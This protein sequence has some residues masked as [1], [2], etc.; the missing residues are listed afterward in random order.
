MAGEIVRSLRLKLSGEEEKGLAKRVT[1][2]T[3]AYQEYLRGRHHWNKRTV[4]GLRSALGHFQKA[5]DLDPNF[6]I[7]YT[8]LADTFN[9]LGYYNNQRPHDAYPK[10]KAAA[11]RAL[12][13]DATLAEAHSSMGYIQI[14]YDLDWPG[15]KASFERALAINPNYATAHHWFAWYWFM[16]EQFDEALAQLR[17]AQ[18]LDPLSL[19]IN[20]HL[21]YALLLAGK[22]DEALEHLTLTKELDPTFPWTYWRLGSVYLELG[23][24]DDAITA[25]GTVVDMTKGGVGLGYYG[26]ALARGGRLDDARAVVTRLTDMQKTRYVSPLEFA[27]VRAG[28][29]ETDAALDALQ[30]AYDDRVSDFARVKLLPWPEAVRCS[31]RFADLLAKLGVGS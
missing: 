6:A 20:D 25:F 22:P 26:L 23:R 5:I 2:N 1:E 30:G 12:A 16:V 13:L 18:E 15:A 29:G 14:F 19:I 24:V 28:L 7:A 3:E 10:G 8:G 21:G 9:I 27:L 4:E 17:R 11:A 31:A